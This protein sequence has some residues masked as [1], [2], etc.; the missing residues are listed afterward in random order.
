MASKDQVR[1]MLAQGVPAANVATALGISESYISQ[2]QASEDFRADVDAARGQAAPADVAYDRKL[3]SIEEQFLDRI[4]SRAAFANLQQSMQGF[5]L[6][7]GARRRRDHAV[8]AGTKTPAVVVNI[9]L[10]ASILPKY[11]LNQQNEIVEVEGQTMVSATPKS[12]EAIISSRKSAQ[13]PPVQQQLETAQMAQAVETLNGL[14]KPVKR[15]TRR[16]LDES[17]LDLL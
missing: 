7:N 11:M 8:L 12:L 9:T 5:K 1:E 17:I 4:E 6:L 16:T 10:P 15:L 2:L 13:S 3:D 14:S